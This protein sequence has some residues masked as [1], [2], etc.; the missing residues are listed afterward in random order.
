[1]KYNIVNTSASSVE[2]LFL[3]DVNVI[4]KKKSVPKRKRKNK[5]YS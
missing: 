5:K 1:M 2:S 4:L 3:R